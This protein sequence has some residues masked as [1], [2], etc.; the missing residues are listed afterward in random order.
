MNIKE[1]YKLR[2]TLKELEG[3]RGRHTEL[4]SVYV[5]AGYELVKIL[6][7]LFQEQGTASNIKD[8][9]TR[10]HVIDSI[11]RMIQH[12][13]LFKR[14]PENGLAV[15]AGNASEKE[16]KVDIKVWSIEPPEPINMRVYRCDQTFLLEPLID[17][18]NIKETFGLIVLDKREGNI[19]LL[20]GT[21]IKNLVT[22]TSGVPG[23]VKTGG[24]SQ[25]RY[26]RLRDEAAHEFYKRI[27]EFANKEFFNK[28][29]LKGILVGGPGTTKQEFVDGNYLLTEIRKKIIAVKDLSY[30][31][32]SGLHDLVERSHE[33]LAEEEI[34][35]EKEIMQ[36]FFEKLARDEEKTTYGL[37]E[38]KKA[39]A[40]GAVDTLL[41]SENLPDK[42]IE[43]LSEEAEKYKTEVKIISTESRE[44]VQLKDI[45]GVA[46]ILRYPLK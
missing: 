28:P 20:R 9:T 22:M 46:A 10:M 5:P 34:T 12:L 16:N 41:L 37:I 45:G 43:E 2:K 8:K 44:G 35:V 29:D 21:N 42:Q 32:E 36:K 14:T 30:T 38:T 26:S 3:I 1:R 7:H 25:Q 24:F 40:L 19:G 15:F 6:N 23:K 4:V 18:I 13:R 17:M 33:V 39:L 11:E 27:A 31:G